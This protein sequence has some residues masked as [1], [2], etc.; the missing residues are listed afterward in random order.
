MFFGF[1]AILDMAIVESVGKIPLQDPPE[2]E[3]CAADLTW[4]KFG[5][6]EHH[7]EVALIPYDRVDAFIIGAYNLAVHV[8]L[9]CE[10]RWIRRA[11]F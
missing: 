4:T 5:N 2:E 8:E 10:S 9:S 11:V 3:F 7:D 1:C 6:A